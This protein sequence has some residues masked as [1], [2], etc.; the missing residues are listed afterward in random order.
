MEITTAVSSALIVFLAYFVRG[1]AGFGS[2]LIAVPLLAL[3]HPLPLVVPLV[4]F[5]DYVGSASQ[6]LKNRASI[7][8]VELWPLI[9]FTFVGVAI[10]LYLLRSVDASLLSKVLG[11]FVLAYAIYQLLPTPDL[12]GSRLTSVPFGTLGGM[13][14]TLFGTGGPFYMIYLNMRGLGKTEI[15]STFAANF[16]IDGGIRLAAFGIVGLFHG[17]SLLYL[18]LALPIA[19]AALFLG[20]HV[21]TG[22]SREAF[23][24][25]ISLL[26]IA[27]GLG[28]FLK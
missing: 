11:G 17:D 5:L 6:G 1:V 28:L 19:A 12:R 25:I 7:R 16:L 8:W 22:L 23:V 14:G 13:I 24:R 20:G 27:S 26:L 3:T 9:P 2:G 18:A 4:V 10:G 21:H 15:R